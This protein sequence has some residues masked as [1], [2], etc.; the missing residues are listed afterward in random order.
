MSS[1]ERRARRKFI[2]ER[3]G[4]EIKKNTEMS[5]YVGTLG[6]RNVSDFLAE[7]GLQDSS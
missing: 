3:C 7:S 2:S 1:K 4:F 5:L 6:G